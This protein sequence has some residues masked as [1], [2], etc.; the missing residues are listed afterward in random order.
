MAKKQPKIKVSFWLWSIFW[1]LIGVMVLIFAKGWKKDCP[2]Y[3]PCPKAGVI[4]TDINEL[5]TFV[6]NASAFVINQGTKSFPEFRKEDGKWWKGDLYV[7]IYE[8]NGNTLVLPP[9]PNLEGTNRL[10]AKDSQG[11]YFVKEMIDYLKSHNSGWLQYHYSKPGEL[12]SSPKL[13]Y[14]KKVNLAGKKVLVGS[15]IYLK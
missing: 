2:S 11:I 15:G 8:M 14:F 7:F 5:V 10:S 1:L 3:I 12:T 9:Q 4:Q 13:S 6:D